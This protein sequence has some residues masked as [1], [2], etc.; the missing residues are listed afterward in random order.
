LDISLRYCALYCCS[1]QH[2]P[3]F[4]AHLRSSSGCPA[5][6]GALRENP[7]GVVCYPGTDFLAQE[8]ERYQRGDSPGKNILHNVLTFFNNYNFYPQRLQELDME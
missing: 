5:V 6:L 4:K 8:I 2:D 3:R 1:F 7:A